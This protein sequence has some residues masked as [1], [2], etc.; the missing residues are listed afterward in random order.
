MTLPFATP[1]ADGSTSKR[2]PT[3]SESTSGFPCGPADKDLFDWLHNESQTQINNLAAQL[4]NSAA[5][6]AVT[7]DLTN[8]SMLDDI[9]LAYSAVIKQ[10]TTL[11]VPSQYATIIDAMNYLSGFLIAE[12]VQVTINVAA[13][14]YN[15]GLL[16]IPGH[17]DGRRIEAIGPALG[18]A[19]P[20]E[21]DFAVS[22]ATDGDR[23]T[24]RVTNDTMLRSRYQAIVT[25]GG[26][27]VD[28]GN[29]SITLTNILFIGTGAGDGLKVENG[30]IYATQVATHYFEN[31][32]HVDG[33]GQIVGDNVSASGNNNAGFIVSFSGA[34]KIT[35]D[36]ALAIGNMGTGI[37]T[38]FGG[39][40]QA[41]GAV[42]K[43]NTD[44]YLASFG[45]NLQVNNSKAQTNENVGY[46]L[47][48]EGV[49]NCQGT[50]CDGHVTG[51]S[52]L[53][54]G[55]INAQ[56]SNCTNATNDYRATTAG[57]VVITGYL[58]DVTVSPA[59]NTVGNG[60]AYIKQ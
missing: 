33:T 11:E 22:G 12:G 51:Y 15:H 4:Q 49:I 1:F 30:S 35:D 10:N 37:G 39:S 43:G 23:A 50:T 53:N 9:L 41:K 7:Y 47:T 16:P 13:G 28:V 27:G 19:V 58:G 31:G 34:I 3:A 5:T 42:S 52:V 18:G 32:V 60:N 45:G 44:G 2:A 21:V 40:I 36:T 38:S 48:N 56:T 20:A 17:P 54:S 46:L 55:M 6:V 59:L 14:T 57:T 8:A 24:D 26:T 29:D 25:C